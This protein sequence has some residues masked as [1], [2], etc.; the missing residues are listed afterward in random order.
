VHELGQERAR[1]PAREVGP[2]EALVDGAAE[3][4][5]DLGDAGVAAAV[6]RVVGEHAGEID[7]PGAVDGDDVLD[8]AVQGDGDGCLAQPRVLDG[9]LDGRE[10]GRVDGRQEVLA[11]GEAAVDGAPVHTRLGRDA[12]DARTGVGG[13]HAGSG[14]QDGFQV[15]RCVGSH[16]TELSGPV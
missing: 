10:A 15:A 3:E 12:R 2:Q 13:E 9:L 16:R 1:P 14:G 6:D 5:V 4:H 11:G 7:G 8:V